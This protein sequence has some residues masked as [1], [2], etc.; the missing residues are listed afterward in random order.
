M[1]NK[2]TATKTKRPLR[3]LIGAFTLGELIVVVTILAVL[4]TIGFLALSGYTQDARNS[5]VATNVRS[6]YTAITAE[7]ALT[8]NSPRYYVIHDTGASLS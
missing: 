4:A 7:S 3:K 8:G 1:D 6:L 5:V 2:I